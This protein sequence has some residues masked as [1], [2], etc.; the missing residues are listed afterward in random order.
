MKASELAAIVGGTLEG[1]DVELSAC[2]GLE[3]SRP[4]DVSFCKD[5]KHIA[6]VESTK[7]S[8]VMLP[9]DWDK[10]A[11]CYI[12]RVEDPN[13]A[14]MQAAAVFAPPEPVRAPGVPYSSD[15]YWY[16]TNVHPKTAEVYVY[17]LDGPFSCH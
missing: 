8:A 6:L 15:K 5:V 10:G 16:Y 1:E 11:P 9:P 7:A 17:V 14:C 4:G 3:E 12:I 13:R 2:A